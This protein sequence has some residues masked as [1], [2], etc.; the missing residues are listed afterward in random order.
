M[1]L[2]CGYVLST[3]FHLL[4][5]E[6]S[7]GG[8]SKIK[9]TINIYSC[10]YTLLPDLYKNQI[11]NLGKAKYQH[12]TT[13]FVDLAD[14]IGLSKTHQDVHVGIWTFRAL[15]LMYVPVWAFSAPQISSSACWN[16]DI[17]VTQI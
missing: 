15:R 1:L 9:A 4:W 6:I 2:V 16:L 13:K 7:L 10:R 17:F 14:L 5:L 12:L 8:A 11:H 3:R